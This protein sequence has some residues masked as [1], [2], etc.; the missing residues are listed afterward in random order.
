MFFFYFPKNKRECDFD[1][2]FSLLVQQTLPFNP[3]EDVC[4]HQPGAHFVFSPA[5]GAQQRLCTK[6]TPTTQKI[7]QKLP[8]LATLESH[9]ILMQTLHTN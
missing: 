7:V 8:K 4:S 1:S 6:Q 3:I 9:N 5:D 2:L